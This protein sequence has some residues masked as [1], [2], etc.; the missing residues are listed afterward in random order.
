MALRILKV[1]VATSC[2]DEILKKL[3][4]GNRKNPCGKDEQ[5]PCQGCR[6]TDVRHTGY[7]LIEHPWG[8]S[9]PPSAGGHLGSLSV[10]PELEASLK[11]FECIASTLG[12][13]KSMSH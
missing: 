12:L 13:R 10:D 1:L 2:V 7:L 9:Y 6:V 4:S 11:S 5:E 8:A 3:D